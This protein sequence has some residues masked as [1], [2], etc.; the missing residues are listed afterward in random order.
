VTTAKALSAVER[1]RLT[2][3]LGKAQAAIWEAFTIAARAGVL[4][5][6]KDLREQHKALGTRIVSI[7]G[8]PIVSLKEL[9]S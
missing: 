6:A 9:F 5:L 4:D 8:G 7:N 3:E 2:R 1:A